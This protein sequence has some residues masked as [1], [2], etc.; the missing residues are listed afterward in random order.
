[1]LEHNFVDTQPTTQISNS[2]SS[3][4]AKITNSISKLLKKDQDFMWNNET[5]KAFNM[6]KDTITS[7]HILMSPNFQRNFMYFLSLQKRQ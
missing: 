2:Y 3:H 1:M 6:R 4:F 5:V 7:T